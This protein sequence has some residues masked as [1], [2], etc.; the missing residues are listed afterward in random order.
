MIINE[1]KYPWLAVAVAAIS[2]VSHQQYPPTNSTINIQ[3]EFPRLQGWS[4]E[5]KEIIQNARVELIE[6]GAVAFPNFLTE[7]AVARAVAE[8]R[9]KEDNAFTTNT[10]HT[11]YL[12]HLDT[13][14]YASNSIYNHPTKTIVASTAYDE[15]A[16]DSVLKELYEDP[17]LLNMVASIVLGDDSKQLYLSEDPLGCCSVN[18]FR[19]GYY[20]GFHYDESEFSVTLMLQEAE[21]GGLFQYTD[22]IRHKNLHDSN[23]SNESED[24]TLELKRT[25][26]VF[27]DH[28]HDP[29]ASSETTTTSTKTFAEHEESAAQ[30]DN[31]VTPDSQDEKE[32]T[33]AAPRLHTLD[34]SPGT[35]LVLA[36]SKSLHRVTAIQGNK[37]RF[38]AVLTFASKPGFCNTP[39]VQ[40]M[41][42]G[43]TATVEKK[44]ETKCEASL[45]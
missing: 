1:L 29:G 15:L 5:G 25:A 9:S 23:E 40:E 35:L 38:V 41:F 27:R 19:P 33:A 31:D 43:R 3:E 24:L 11:A 26:D 6:H 45:L 14:R 34:F 12:K 42:W 10:Q 4:L 13:T 36:G 28:E 44:I 8:M 21:G 32:D 30:E 22:P 37:S 39:E 2:G 20:H 17:R 7:D 18:V 16:V